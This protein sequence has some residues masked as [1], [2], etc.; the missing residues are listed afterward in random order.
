MIPLHTGTTL[1]AASLLPDDPMASLVERKRVVDQAV[2]LF[3][4]LGSR[5]QSNL[6]IDVHVHADTAAVRGSASSPEITGA[7]VDVSAWPEGT[8]WNGIRA[9]GP[10]VADLVIDES[11]AVMTVVT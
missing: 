1:L 8:A 7:I 3:R 6:R 9:T 11:D 5:G 4:Q 10:S 2:E